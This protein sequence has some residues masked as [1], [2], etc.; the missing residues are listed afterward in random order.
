MNDKE[1]FSAQNVK[2][3]SKLVSA[4]SDAEEPQLPEDGNDTLFWKV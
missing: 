1:T 4:N 3:L 2:N